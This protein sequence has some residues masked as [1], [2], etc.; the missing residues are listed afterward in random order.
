[1][2]YIDR[3]RLVFVDGL[4]GG[5]PAFTVYDPGQD[6]DGTIAFG[7]RLVGMTMSEGD[8]SEP[9]AVM[10]GGWFRDLATGDITGWEPDANDLLWAGDGGK[11]TTT[12]PTTGP[13]ILVGT[14]LGSGI[15]SVQLTVFPGPSDLSWVD[16]DALEDLDVLIWDAA[17]GQWQP[18]QLVHGTDLA[19]LDADDHPQ[20][21]NRRWA[22]FLR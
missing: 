19:G 17:S 7:H 6:M 20:Y 10:R 21:V 2:S 8:G 3:F 4:D 5:R 9:M 11:P 15:A 14:Y 18:R 22:W 1:M 13:Q 16:R 12:R